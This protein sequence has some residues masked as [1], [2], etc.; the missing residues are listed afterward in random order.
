MAA[1]GAFIS[2]SHEDRVWLLDLFKHLSPAVRR[3]LELWYDGKSAAGAA[4]AEEID[5]AIARCGA[6]VLLVSPNF[7]ASEFIQSHELPAVLAAK[8]DRG[9]GVLWML[10]SDC[11]YEASVGSIQAL[12]DVKRPLD[13]LPKPRRNA[14]LKQIGRQIEDQVGQPRSDTGNSASAGQSE[15]RA[16]YQV[17]FSGTIEQTDV[18]RLLAQLQTIVRDPRLELIRVESG[19]IRLTLTGG[20][21]GFDRLQHAFLDGELASVTGRQPYA[22]RMLA[23]DATA[24]TQSRLP[25]RPTK[26]I[27]ATSK[28]QPK[29]TTR[30]P[31]IVADSG[32]KTARTTDGVLLAVYAPLARD[33]ARA[34]TDSASQELA[35]HPF[36]RALVKVAEQCAHVVALIDLTD[37]DTFLVEIEAG[38]PQDLKVTS[39]WKQAMNEPRTLA[40]FLRHAH[41]RHP[42]AAIVLALE[43]Y[44][45]GF[46]PDLGHRQLTAV[47]VT[48]GGRFEWKITGRNYV[49]QYGD[50]SPV[51]PMGAPNLPMGIPSVS[52]DMPLSTWGLGYAL[53]MA[54]AAGVPRLSVIHFSHCFKPSVEVMHTIA[55]QS[56]FASCYGEPITV[57]EYYPRVFEKLRAA[58]NASAEQVASWL[59][60]ANREFADA[61]QHLPTKGEVVRLDRMNAIAERIDDVAD[62]L[63]AALQSAGSELPQVVD[64]IKAAIQNAQRY[65]T[66]SPQQ[67]G[68]P[69]EVTDVRGLAHSLQ[70][71]DFGKFS[72]VVAMAAEL[73]RAMADTQGKGEIGHLGT[74]SSIAS[75]FNREQHYLGMSILLPDPLLRGVWDWRSPYYLCVTPDSV[76]PW[77]A[78]HIIDFLK[79]TDWVDFLIEYHKSSKFVG[80]LAPRNPTS[81]PNEATGELSKPNDDNQPVTEAR[82][83]RTPS[84]AG[85]SKPAGGKIRR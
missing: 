33:E 50:G 72:T 55:A 53:R 44:G 10:I 61:R 65:D 25:V 7:I 16:V 52:R 64:R 66:L 81:S 31:Q 38:K 48:E 19:S 18:G 59:A 85:S 57:D 23:E 70:R 74:S 56:H 1:A 68:G 42:A 43:N 36:F 34:S 21:D 12:H 79:D 17:T 30:L 27:P 14:L 8:A 4:W 46:V 22:L 58:R 51:A 63:I 41:R 40:G 78:P 47:E 32:A 37:H 15:S 84:Q 80:L 13:S 6:A 83:D 24:A 2:Y 35:Q 67:F 11:D 76:R 5:R 9:L 20:R 29:K 26:R 71:Q 77:V 28:T 39:R 75:D 60:D 82:P 54:L 62:A 49:P 3:G 45:A 73:E 69:D